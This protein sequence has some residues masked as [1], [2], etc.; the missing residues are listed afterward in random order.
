MVRGSENKEMF[1]IEDNPYA[2]NRRR[3]S[4]RESVLIECSL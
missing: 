2:E 4:E 1:E 3:S